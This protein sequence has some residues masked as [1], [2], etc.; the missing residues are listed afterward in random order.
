[1]KQRHGQSWSPEEEQK[2][3]VAFLAGTP[4]QNLANLLE[5]SNQAI[6]S[7]LNRLGLIESQMEDNSS[8]LEVLPRPREESAPNPRAR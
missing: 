3:K 7:R 6:R 8:M 1:M 2:L 4:I 5:R